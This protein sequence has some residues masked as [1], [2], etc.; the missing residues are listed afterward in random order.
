[1]R[2][3]DITTRLTA[4]TDGELSDAER[5]QVEQH[6][7][8]CPECRGERDRIA[9]VLQIAAQWEPERPAQ[10]MARRPAQT[11]AR[12][13]RVLQDRLLRSAPPDIMTPTELM[14]YLAIDASRYE[15]IVDSLPRIEIAGQ[16]RFRRTSVD[17][18]LAQRELPG[19]VVQE[20]R[21]VLL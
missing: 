11:M 1:M 2:C 4:Y 14:A 20:A 12:R 17:S 15:Q 19:G 16:W 6:L 8:E 18:W 9:R 10:T 21:M 13:I 5:G 3:A 7:R